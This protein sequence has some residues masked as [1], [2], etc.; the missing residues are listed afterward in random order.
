MKTKVLFICTHNSAQ[1]R[2][3]EGLLRFLYGKR[4]EA[5]RVGTQPTHINPHAIKVLAE[6]G[7]DISAQYLKKI[8]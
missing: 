1:S 5:Y 4:Y 8:I 3:A 6:M 7:I 2:M